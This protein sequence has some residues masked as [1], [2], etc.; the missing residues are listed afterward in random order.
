MPI[1]QT[2]YA[3]MIIATIIIIA[4]IA[5]AIITYSIVVIPLEYTVDTLQTSYTNISETMHF[6]NANS[7]N[8]TL[9]LFPW[10]LAAA[11][12]TFIGLIFVWYFVYAHKMEY[13]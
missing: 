7:V 6:D 10:F 9:G 1:S 12:L 2:S 4:F 13:E 5:V 8:N 11:L 3:R